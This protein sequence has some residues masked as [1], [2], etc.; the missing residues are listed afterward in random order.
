MHM[1]EKSRIKID[2]EYSI[3]YEGFLRKKKIAL[4]SF[5]GG[6]QCQDLTSED[7]EFNIRTVQEMKTYKMDVSHLVGAEFW[8]LKEGETYANLMSYFFEDDSKKIHVCVIADIH[9]K[10]SL[11]KNGIGSKIIQI[12]EQI[13]MDNN[14]NYIVGEME[15][16]EKLDE[17]KEFFR[18]NGFKMWKEGCAKFSGWVIV[19]KV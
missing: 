18:K 17:R 13:C 12:I 1:S 8:R 4:R 19:K 15:N 16:D 2:R 6:Y 7:Q 3:E 10:Q 5:C 11:Q 9:V 14:V